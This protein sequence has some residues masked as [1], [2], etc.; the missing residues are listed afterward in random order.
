VFNWIQSAN[1]LAGQFEEAMQTD[2]VP[3]ARSNESA[4][5]SSD[6]K[7]VPKEALDGS[8]GAEGSGGGM[9]AAKA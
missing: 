3:D 5:T 7:F 9:E 8:K 2:D 6:D 1:S 4:P